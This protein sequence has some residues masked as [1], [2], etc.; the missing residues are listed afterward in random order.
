LTRRVEV[1]DP[2]RALDLLHA[3]RRHSDRLE[4]LVELEVGSRLLGRSLRVA[5]RRSERGQLPGD[6]GEVVVD[7]RRRLGLARDDER[8]PRLV[9]QDRVDLVHDSVRMAALDDAVE[10]H[11]HVVPQVVEAELG[12]RPV[13][14]VGVVGRLALVERHHRLDVGDAHPE[15]LEDGPVPL[16]VALGEVV[17]GRDEMGA[18]A[19]EAV[20]VE[21]EARDERLALAGLHLRDVALVED[22]PAHELHVEH[23]LVGSAL[24][25]LA[26]GC[27]RLEGEVVEA[28]AVLEPLPELRRLALEVGGGQ[29]LEVGLERG[30]VRGLVLEPLEAAALADAENSFEVADL[31]GSRVAA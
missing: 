11:G 30:D 27:E 20:E 7:L 24:A 9:D 8:R 10:A 14:D 29:L 12:V 15:R 25:R 23:A 2:D 13:R 26:D 19:G 6:T 17:V 3:L 31:H 18:A 16:G 21:G 1:L 4:L 22:D 5:G 28:L